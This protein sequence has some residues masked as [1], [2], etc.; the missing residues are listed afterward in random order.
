MTRSTIPGERL[1]IYLPAGERARIMAL[2]P[3][4]ERDGYAVRTQHGRV[5]LASVLRALAAAYER[6][7]TRTRDERIGK[8]NHAKG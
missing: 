8:V 7:G 3:R 2:A 1:N 6:T 5:T 4:L